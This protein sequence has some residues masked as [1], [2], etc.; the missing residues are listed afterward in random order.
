MNLYIKVEGREWK[1]SSAEVLRLMGCADGRAPV[2]G[3]AEREVQGIKVWVNA[4]GLY[5]P[6]RH[7]LM[8]ECPVCLKRMSVGR[9]QQHSKVHRS[10]S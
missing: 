8:A 1:A 10:A 6:G 4:L 7:R 3:V 2:D 9:L 5:A